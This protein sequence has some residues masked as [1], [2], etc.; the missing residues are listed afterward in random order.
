MAVALV[1][2]TA[3]CSAPKPSPSP[4]ASY[5]SPPAESVFTEALAEARAAKPA[6]SDA[7]IRALEKS[8]KSGEMSYEDVNALLQDTFKCFDD[9]GVKYI[10]QPDSE[11]VPGFKVPQYGIAAGGIEVGDACQNRFSE[12]AFEGYQRQPRAVELRDKALEA[13][14]PSVLSCLR[15]HGVTI[16]DAATLDEIRRAVGDLFVATSDGPDAVMC[17][18]YL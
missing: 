13:D 5:A 10:L 8:A 7:Q 6:V 3:A 1:T 11:K 14:R 17:T 2:A 9:A 4:T 16:D 12:F 18:R 15:A